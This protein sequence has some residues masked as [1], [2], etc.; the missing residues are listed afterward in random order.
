MSS[1]SVGCGASG[2]TYPPVYSTTTRP[3]NRAQ[4]LPLASSLYSQPASS[5][6]SYSG[7]S[8]TVPVMIIEAMSVTGYRVNSIGEAGRS[9]YRVSLTV[10][11]AKVRR[12]QT[13]YRRAGLVNQ[14]RQKHVIGLVGQVQLAFDSS[15]GD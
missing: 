1:G 6:T 12:H 14:G 13:A 10:S 15:Q 8:R 7:A 3:Q 5:S 9:R 11:C 2:K 4:R